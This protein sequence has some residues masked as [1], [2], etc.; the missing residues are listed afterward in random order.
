MPYRVGGRSAVAGVALL[1]SVALP[2]VAAALC[3]NQPSAVMNAYQICPRALGLCTITAPQ[4]IDA[5]TAS[6]PTLGCD[7]D[8]GTRPVTFA[9]PIDVAAGTLRVQA[10]TI[11]VDG[12]GDVEAVAPSQDVAVEMLTHGTDC[13]NGVGD[14]VVG[15]G[16]VV[17]AVLPRTIRLAASCRVVL[18]STSQLAASASGN[19]GGLFGNGGVIDV[20]ART[21]IVQAGPLRATAAGGFGGD[22]RVTAGDDVQVQR[23]IDVRSLGDGEGGTITLRA[24]DATL[25]GDVAG[26]TLTVASDL[27]ADGSADSDGTT[28]EDGGTVALE[29]TGGITLTATGTIRANGGSPDGAGGSVTML[30][31]QQPLGVLT[32]LDGDVTLTGPTTL[33]GASIGDGGDLEVTAGR[34]FWLQGA[35]DLTGGGDDASAG[36]VAVITGRHVRLDAAIDANG[37]VAAAGGGAVEMIAGLA[38]ADATLTVGKPIDVSAGSDSEAGDVSLAACRLTVQPNVLV[39]ARS[40]LPSREPVIT[41]AAP[42]ALSLG[43]GSRFLAPTGGAARIVRAPATTLSIGSGVVFSPPAVTTVVPPDRSPMPP[44]PVCG[45]GIRQS[46]EP[47][48]PGA[49]ADGA[50]CSSD[51]LRFICPTTTPSPTATPLP[52]GRTPTPTPTHTPTLTATPTPT[53]TTS[54]PLPPLQPRSVLLCERTLAKGVS[55]VV[56]NELTFLETCATESLACLALGDADRPACLAR[57]ARRCTS[58]FAKLV[59]VRSTFATAFGKACS[60]PTGLPFA[61]LRAPQGLAFAELEA[62]CEDDVGLALTSPS[63]VLACVEAG[64]C[65]GERALATALPRLAEVVPR[66]FDGGSAGFCV[67]PATVDP[68]LPLGTLSTRSALRCQRGIVTAGRKLLTRELAAASRCVDALLGCRLAGGDAAACAP[69]ADRCARKLGALTDTNTGARARLAATVLKACGGVTPGALLTADGL[70]FGAS[71]AACERFGLPAPQSVVDLA[72]CLGAAYGCAAGTLV[73][74]AVPLVD[75]ELAR[76]GLALGDDFACPEPS[77]S[78]TTTPRPGETTTPTATIVPTPTATS[79]PVTQA[80]VLIPGGGTTASDCITEWTVRAAAA[81]PPSPTAFTCVDGDPTCDGDGV[82]NDRCVFALGLCLAGTDPRLPDCPAAPAIGT[83]T[84]QAPQPTSSNPIDAANAAALLAAVSDLTGATPG[85]AGGNS[86]SFA[87]PLVLTTDH[88]TA[89]AAVTVER[90]TLDR[91]TE[92]FR[93]RAVSAT[94]NGGTGPDDG[95]ILYLTCTAPSS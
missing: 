62:A 61:L 93:A 95:D 33:R 74:R 60:E 80:T 37:R 76:V 21:S 73:R 41:L 32:P 14:L 69:V 52:T 12:T 11:T 55:R 7:L 70:G 16:I 79:T 87:P 83:F 9:A 85:G 25:A 56:G 6:C 54:P 42:N 8:F 44:C 89:A 46:G 38:S 22:V 47:C 88:C 50:C 20:Q 19:V 27:I 59:R 26:G 45:D 23:T 34:D 5:P 92:R 86:F 58:R 2:A 40:A 1:L 67:V 10:A 49:G 43:A 13:A 78:P 15:G 94:A 71:A 48:D 4:H 18:E 91:R 64:D 35:V 30:T 36:S 39:D 68:Q 53:V 57:V 75:D 77:P 90:R 3:C 31:Q 81:E 29:A 65:A 72:P 84:L 82:V 24:G 66:V 28:G 17:T 51:C 63:A